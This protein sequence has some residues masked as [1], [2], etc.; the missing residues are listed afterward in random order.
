MI[1][2]RI[3]TYV[4]AF[5]CGPEEKMDPSNYSIVE[6]L[7]DGARLQIRALRPADRDELLG[8]VG[9]LSEESIRR[10]FF[11]P[12]RHFSEREIEYFSNVD[13]VTHVALV[14]VLDEDGQ[15][16]IVGSGRYIV[17]EPGVAE[18]A[19]IVDDAHQ[20]LGIGGRLMKHLATIAR[21]A[22]LRELVA[23][24]LPGNAAMLAVFRK[25]GLEVESKHAGGIVHVTLRLI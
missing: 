9:R 21:D 8:A 15:P 12:K 25:S 19:F 17:T 22:G 20:G 11:A 23:E 4:L 2:V 3:A 10:R 6:P 1:G 14:A 13:F 5:R 24:V 7:R 18:V 16:T